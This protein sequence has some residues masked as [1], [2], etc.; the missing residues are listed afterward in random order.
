MN[1]Y[2]ITV[3][4]SSRLFVNDLDRT[5]QNPFCFDRIMINLPAQIVYSNIIESYWRKKL[6][7]VR[8]IK[9][10]ICVKNITR[11]F[12][13]VIDVDYACFTTFLYKLHGRFSKLHGIASSSDQHRLE[14]KV[15]GEEPSHFTVHLSLTCRLHSSRV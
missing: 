10:L 12:V 6:I 2:L 5:K 15:G 1:D 8:E 11:S 4:I 7:S 3:T 14:G 13:V 9:Y